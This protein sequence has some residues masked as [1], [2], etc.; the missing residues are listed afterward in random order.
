MTTDTVASMARFLSDA[1][2]EA[3]D[4][5]A[6][7]DETLADLADGPPLVVQQVVTGGPDGDVT[8]NVRAGGGAVSVRPGPADD[9]TIRF[10]QDHE[11]A[12]AIASGR[13]SAQRAFMTGRL[14]VGGD[15]RAVLDR[16][17]T[18]TA[19]ADVFAAVRATTDDLAPTP[20]P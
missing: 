11:T 2:L 16:G 3:L 8:Y 19:L 18:L 20:P 13:L 5:A 10:R 15:L 6:R 7:A 1:W 14:Q 12:T 4:R 9:A 17:P